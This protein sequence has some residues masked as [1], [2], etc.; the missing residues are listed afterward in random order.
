MEG[1]TVG[2]QRALA[3]LVFA[4]IM[5]V[6]EAVPYPVSSVMI[7]ILVTLSLGYSPDPDSSD[8]VIGTSKA[9]GMGLQEF[10]TSSVAL[11]VTALALA[12]AMQS[13]GLHKRLAFLILRFAGEKV[14]NL[15]FGSIV[16]SLVLAFFR[17]IS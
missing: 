16:I 12:A 15:I 7:L 11:V 13:T 1:L 5:W 3:I 8:G 9:L 6:T 4:I 2:G 17:T 14:R 10:A